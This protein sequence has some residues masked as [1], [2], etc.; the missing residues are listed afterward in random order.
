M[1]ITFG[2]A[3]FGALLCGFSLGGISGAMAGGVVATGPAPLKLSDHKLDT[4][5][6]LE[7]GAFEVNN[8]LHSSLTHAKGRQTVVVRL[9]DSSRL[10]QVNGMRSSNK[11]AMRIAQQDAFLARHASRSSGMRVLAQTQLV[12][13][14]V[15]LDVDASALKALAADRAVAR[16]APVGNYELDLTE[17]VPYIG[18]SAVQAAG[19][20]GAGVKVAI[21][22]SGID[23]THA[24]LGG[25]GTLAAYEAAYGLSPADPRNTT[26]DG[27]F[28]TSKVVEGF[29][30]VGEVWPGGP[31]APDDDPIDFGAHG[32]NVADIT[33]GSAGVAPGV[34]LYAVK[35]CS[36]VSSSCSGVA[37]IQGMDYA[38]DPN[39]DGST[40]DRVD[41]INM[42]LGSGYGQPF[43]DDLSQ[44]VNNATEMGV[45]T[46][47][48]AGNGA[49]LPYITG[50]PAAAATALS[51]A[52]TQVPSAALQLLT[53]DDTDYSAVFQAWSTPVAA[54]VVAPVQYGDGAGGNLNGC[55]PFA[56]GSLAGKI[57]LIDRGA[58]T[59]TSKIFNVGNAGGLVGIIG[60]VA[61]GAP[62]SGGFAD[63]GGPITI[64]GF[65]ISLADANAIRASIAAGNDT[66]VVDPDNVLPLVQGM[67]GSSSRGPRNN[68]NLLKP[69][70][71]APGA[72]LSA[73]VGTGTGNR[74]F[75]GTSGAA[76]MVTG[77]AALLI[78]AFRQGAIGDEDEVSPQLLKALL[79][80]T[81]E[82]DIETDPFSGLAPISRI[83]GGEVRVNN[84]LNAGA[85][86]WDDETLQGGVS[87][88]FVD[89]ADTV[90]LMRR[91]NV[92]SL[93]D[94]RPSRWTITP[95]FRF[96]DDEA[97][98]A[99]SVSVH[100]PTITLPAGTTKHFKV[101]MEIDGSK[102]PGNF[103]N[104]GSLGNNPAPLTI[105]EY[106]GYLTLDNGE[107]Q[108]RLPWH[109]LPRRSAHVSASPGS[110]SDDAMQ[111]V[112]LN[113]KGANT[114][115]IDA[116][117]LIATSPD[118]PEGAAGE[119]SPTP[120]LRAVGMTT[121]PVPAGFCSASESFLW[122]F[123]VNTWE[124]RSHLAP[125]SHQIGLDIDR[126][127]IEDFIVLNRD[128]S[129][130]GLGDGRQATFALDTLSGNASAFFFAEHA[131]NTNN[132]ALI[133]CAEQI[134]MSA[135]DL[136]VTTVNAS[137]FAQDFYFGGPGDLITGLAITPGAER[138]SVVVDDIAPFSN[139][140]MDIVDNGAFPGDT[141]QPGVLLFTN[142]D[143]GTGAR[144]GATEAT[145]ALILTRGDDDDDSDSD[146]ESRSKR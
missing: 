116:Y 105:N 72:S 135:A 52:Q 22:D 36:A 49:N 31:L 35:V 131:T 75:G 58:C 125:V 113:N 62:F 11:R 40:D 45:L 32:T 28:P 120:D 99:I 98:G 70:I 117:T 145:E 73:F 97:S 9:R 96:A 132:T 112:A 90:K 18:A 128:L 86:A 85:V 109:I 115:Q 138:Y 143:R 110:L 27:L 95:S 106:D 4:P 94:G 38:V 16:I 76:P 71:G 61:A 14:A 121:I 21:L 103:M 19:F 91:V 39:G 53:V 65:M 123:A 3:A 146:S 12:L 41:L 66:G 10:L 92:R 137:V 84:A 67:V 17:T 29:D 34:D 51:V 26:R 139:G 64:P 25:P 15:F 79:M 77:S 118:I 80:N 63:P 82:I 47:A 5:I 20:D 74:V 68:D 6:T 93:S 133:I 87:F 130:T 88:G 124:R 1:R 50:S 60:L 102:L 55:A 7:A 100:P 2:R 114:A 101:K 129:F 108:I 83:G 13:N 37:L 107:Q 111:T 56:P 57:V 43:D 8:S 140:T 44:A 78:D 59:F 119:Q 144:G 126:D 127:G 136:G 81:G 48:S 23:Y 89:V 122:V 33:G 104:S 134:G 141:D 69:E 46:V 30:F 54:T 24:S 142:G 42:S